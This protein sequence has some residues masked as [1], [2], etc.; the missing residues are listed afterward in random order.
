MGGCAKSNV[1]PSLPRVDKI[2]KGAKPADLPVELPT[3]VTL[4][5][6][7]VTG[8]NKNGK[9]RRSDKS[10]EIMQYHVVKLSREGRVLIPAG[11]R[12]ELGLGEGT[13][14]NLAVENGEIRLFDQA[15]ALKRARA[16]A[17]KYKRPGQSVVAELL[18]ERRAEAKQE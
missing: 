7:V 13:S 4:V 17:R 5:V 11:V 18:R 15:H 3:D 1:Q 16:I 8:R 10:R 9:I 6:V 12:A 14:L 2:L